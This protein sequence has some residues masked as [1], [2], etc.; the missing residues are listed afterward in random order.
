MPTYTSRT[1]CRVCGSKDVR[2]VFS[3]GAQAVS[4]FVDRSEI[5]SGNVVPIEIDR[6]ESCTLVQARHAPPAEVL[7]KGTYWYRS[8]VTQTMCDALR[9][10]T[11]S[12]EGRVDLRDGDAVLDIGSNDGTLLRSYANKRLFTVGVE[13]AKNLVDEGRVGIKMLINDLWNIGVWQS[14]SDVMGEENE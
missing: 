8:G 12:I 3:L 5:K 4:D 9:D 14:F 7:Y 13:P 2:P 6:C 10:V 11:R 1:T